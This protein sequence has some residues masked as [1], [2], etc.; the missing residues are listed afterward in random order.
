MLITFVTHLHR[1]LWDFL[2]VPDQ[3]I[4]RHPPFLGSALP[5]CRPKV[6]DQESW[7][8]PCWCFLSGAP[9]LLEGH[10]NRAPVARPPWLLHSPVLPPVMHGPGCSVAFSVHSGDC[11]RGE[12]QVLCPSLVSWAPGPAQ[13]SKGLRSHGTVYL[14]PSSSNHS[15]RNDGQYPSWSIRL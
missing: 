1:N 3:C 9:H 2:V 10:L 11:I 5:S 14:R 8:A 13:S 4:L 6:E 15:C 12:G 7:R